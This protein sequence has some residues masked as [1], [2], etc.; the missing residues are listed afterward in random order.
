MICI[1][2]NVDFANFRVKDVKLNQTT[3]MF[4]RDDSFHFFKNPTTSFYDCIYFPRIIF[5][6][7]FFLSEIYGRNRRLRDFSEIVAIEIFIDD[8]P[9][10]IEL[11][12]FSRTVREDARNVE[13]DSYFTGL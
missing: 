11:R 13:I 6:S 2:N 3:L 10:I 12:A 7:Y 4:A 8:N 5:F 9:W 1:K